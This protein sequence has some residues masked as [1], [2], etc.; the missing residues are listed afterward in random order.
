MLTTVIIVYF[1][2]HIQTVTNGAPAV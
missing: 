1:S 2:F